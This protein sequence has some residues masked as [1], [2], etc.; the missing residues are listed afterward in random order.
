MDRNLAGPMVLL[1][2]SS[3]SICMIFSIRESICYCFGE[4]AG[5]DVIILEC[6]LKA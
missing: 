5:I 3:G 2:I 6:S 1:E 4:I